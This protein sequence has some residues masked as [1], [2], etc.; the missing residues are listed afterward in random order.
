MLAYFFQFLR[1]SGL[2]LHSGAFAP[3]LSSVW[4]LPP[5]ISHSSPGSLRLSL[6]SPTCTTLSQRLPEG[7]EVFPLR[8]PAAPPAVLMIPVTVHHSVF[9]CVAFCWRTRFLRD[10]TWC[11][12]GERAPACF[13]YQSSL[14]LASSPYQVLSKYLQDDLINAFNARSEFCAYF[15]SLRRVWVDTVSRIYDLSQGT[16]CF[17]LFPLSCLH[18]DN[19]S[20]SSVLRCRSW[21]GARWSPRVSWRLRRLPD[22]MIHFLNLLFH[23]ASFHLQFSKF[24]KQKEQALISWVS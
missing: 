24:M 14:C 12:L 10:Q 17:T 8:T 7:A 3:A 19:S 6:Q 23:L 22:P 13:I 11:P 18:H 5:T 4:N 20:M 2:P 16:K 21:S 9:I 1:C 15:G